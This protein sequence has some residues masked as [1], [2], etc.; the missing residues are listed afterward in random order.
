MTLTQADRA[1]ILKN[2]TRIVEEK[3]FNPNHNHTGWEQVIEA[4]TPRILSAET[5][6][7]FEAAMR[8]LI[9]QLGTSHTAFFHENGERIP[10]RY[11]INATF[12]QFKTH[13]GLRWVFQDVLEGGPAHC[14]GL[15]PGEIL[16]R[17]NS[18]EITPPN[19]PTFGIGSSPELSVEGL[20]WRERTVTIEIPKQQAKDRPPM[21]EPHSVSHSFLPDGIALLKVTVFP[22][23][24]GVK[25]ASEMDAA[26]AAI[27]REK[28]SRLIVDLRANIGG[29]LGSL[30]L[31][32]YLTPGKLPIGHSLTKQ[33]A[34]KGYRKESLPRIKKIPSSK[35]GLIWMAIRFRYLQKDRS[36][37][38]V[39]EGLGPQPFHRRVV[40]LVNEFTNSAG[41][42]VAGFAAENGLATIVGTRTAGAVLGGANFRV[43]GGYKF[44]LPITGWFTWQGNALEGEG[45]SPDVPVE[46]SYEALRAG[47]DS[48]LEKAIEIVR[49]L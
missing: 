5:D 18:Q 29:G 19:S 31:L 40:L 39:T 7:S 9:T 25:F 15:K 32:S 6:E 3:H 38:L 1:Q 37:V 26:V 33:R 8:S 23:D 21:I 49:T 45:V 36:M 22:G 11:V 12:H 35:A 34:E 20:D 30:R 17:V 48:Q 2:V 42:M 10:A 46:V 27:K 44:R 28:Y 24:V 14:S 43:G 47:R 41:E 4:E 16:L 13:R